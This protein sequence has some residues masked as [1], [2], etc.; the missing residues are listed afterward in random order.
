MSRF[1]SP[2]PSK[3]A[4]KKVQGQLK[5]LIGNFGTILLAWKNDVG[6]ILK[7]LDHYESLLDKRD[8]INRACNA[9]SF[10]SRSFVEYR[11]LCVTVCCKISFEIE[12]TVMQ[13]RMFE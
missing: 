3:Q 5:T 12:N 6:E 8:T 4:V 11:V 13:L 2:T 9:D 1:L 10:M 7:L